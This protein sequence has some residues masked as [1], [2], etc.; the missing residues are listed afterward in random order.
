MRYEN[1]QVGHCQK[2]L[3]SVGFASLQ[4]FRQPSWTYF[5]DPLHLHGD[6]RRPSSGSSETYVGRD[7]VPSPKVPG[8]SV[9]YLGSSV[10]KQMRQVRGPYCLPGLGRGAACGCGWGWASGRGTCSGSTGRV[11]SELELAYGRGSREGV[12]AAA[13][14]CHVGS[15]SMLKS[16]GCGDERRFWECRCCTDQ[17]RSKNRKLKKFKVRNHDC[18]VRRVKKAPM[19]CRE[20]TG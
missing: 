14:Q 20:T 7:V 5:C 19:I 18:P 1:L 11:L 13:G 8:I 12:S 10:S 2:F 4:A 6:S 15:D 3:A 16:G 9:G 17:I